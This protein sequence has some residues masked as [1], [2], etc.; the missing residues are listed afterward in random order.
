M[1][2]NSFQELSNILLSQKGSY[3]PINCLLFIEMFIVNSYEMWPMEGSGFSVFGGVG[4]E[5]AKNKF[6]YT[7]IGNINHSKEPVF[8]TRF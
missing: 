4:N 6:F 2:L 8:M 5:Y 3:N 7:I 1:F